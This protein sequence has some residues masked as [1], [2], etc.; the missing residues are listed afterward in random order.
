MT[1]QLTTNPETEVV[2]PDDSIIEGEL[3]E[4]GQPEGQATAPEDDTD[5]VEKDGQKYRVPKALKNEFL[6]HS[7]YT[8]KTQAIADERKQ[9]EQERGA[10]RN[11]NDAMLNA[12]AEVISI[13][14]TLAQYQQVDWQALSAQDP[15]KAQQLWFDYSQ[16]KD[17]RQQAVE[18]YGQADQQ[19][20]LL[21]QQELAKRAEETKLTIQRDIK[22]WS[23]DLQNKLVD[24]AKSL[25][26]QDQQIQLAL[27]ADASSVK[28][29]HMAYQ[30]T[31]MLKKAATPPATAKPDPKPVQKVAGV[32]KATKDPSDMS[33][34]EFAEWR[35]RQIAQRR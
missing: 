4:D 35:R 6:M 9:L 14:K 27:A 22:D 21:A 5:E 23:P 13:D 1:D 3:A 19:R 31:Q 18:T 7:D 30:F 11:I 26:Y 15:A 17:R 29:L 25:G 8:R 33:D 16:L 34:K 12:R 24:F 2:T 20:N 32:A 10:L 28:L